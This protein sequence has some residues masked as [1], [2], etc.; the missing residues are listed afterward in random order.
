MYVVSRAQVETVLGGPTGKTT[1]F[2]LVFIS[3][4]SFLN[5]LFQGIRSCV[6]LPDHLLQDDQARC[7]Q[8]R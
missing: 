4:A 6:I 5:G 8:L 7:R 3:L 2:I 1:D